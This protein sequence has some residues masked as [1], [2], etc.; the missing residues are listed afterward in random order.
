MVTTAKVSLIRLCSE[1]K[2]KK[3]G[4]FRPLDVQRVF[5]FKVS[6]WYNI[7]HVW[8]LIDKEKVMTIAGRKVRRLWNEASPKH[9]QALQPWWMQAYLMCR[10]QESACGNKHRQ[11]AGFKG[12]KMGDLLAFF[13]T[14]FEEM[15][16]LKSCGIESMRTEET[17]AWQPR[18]TD[19]Y[20]LACIQQY[21]VTWNDFK[22]E[23]GS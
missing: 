14:N 16:L 1:W 23:Q 9:R 22:Y 12:R 20:S 5:F 11:I 15:F 13:W 4:E 6:W 18:N 2:R 17:V 3:W 19:W 8:W 10:N 7:K 21:S